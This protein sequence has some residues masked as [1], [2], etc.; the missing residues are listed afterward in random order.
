MRGNRRVPVLCR[1]DEED[2]KLIRSVDEEVLRLCAAG[3]L[4]KAAER[5]R[6]VLR[7]RLSGDRKQ[8]EQHWA[9]LMNYADFFAHFEL[10]RFAVPIWKKI[11]SG[12]VEPEYCEERA[13]YLNE[14][15][16][17]LLSAGDGR[18]LECFDGVMRLTNEP[19][20]KLLTLG[21][22]GDAHAILKRDLEKSERCFRAARHLAE[23]N[24]ANPL[25]GEQAKM[26]L[27]QV[28][29]ELAG[30]LDP[31]LEESRI[32]ALRLGAK[33]RGLLASLK[34]P[35]FAPLD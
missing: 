31:E 24:G 21:R 26:R 34:I 22:L 15:G 3:D 28:R 20:R 18:A 32:A 8:R 5:L 13:Y 19:A 33:N 1:I 4:D 12:L 27:K 29:R 14:L 11:I 2:W 10:W 9:V 35:P 30:E 7:A 23:R 25:H 6:R 17:F 16:A